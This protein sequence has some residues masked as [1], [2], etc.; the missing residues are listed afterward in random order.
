MRILITG[1]T[2]FVGSHL[3]ELALERGAEVFGTYRWRSRLDNI[4]HLLTQIRLIECDLR[5]AISVRN[6]VKEAKPDWI[7]HLAAQSFV[8]ASWTAPAE[9]TVCSSF[10]RGLSTTADLADLRLSLIRVSLGK[11]HELKRLCKSQ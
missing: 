7:F 2:G 5:D 8:P 10:A 11:L 3:A 1:I 9:V 4:Q 6:A